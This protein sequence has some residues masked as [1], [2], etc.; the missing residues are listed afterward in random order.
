MLKLGM[1]QRLG[2][3]LSVLWAF[4]A[5]TYQRMT[6]IERANTFVD[7]SYKVCI[8]SLNLDH[9]FD[10]S[11][12]LAQIPKDLAIWLDGSWASVAVVAFLPIP[13]AWILAFVSL[14]TLQWVKQGRSIHQISD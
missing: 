3:V 8:E 7:W 2:I 10:Y 12:C 5:C 1:W 14:K 13:V 6:D 4:G 11:S 9:I